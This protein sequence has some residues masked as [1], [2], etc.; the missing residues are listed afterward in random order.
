MA[1]G[2]KRASTRQSSAAPTEPKLKSGGGSSTV[3]P[4][5]TPAPAPARLPQLLPGLPGLPELPELPG[6]PE[7][8]ALVKQDNVVAVQAALETD[9][10]VR[11]SEDMVTHMVL[12]IRSHDMLEVFMDHFREGREGAAGA[13]EAAQAH[14]AE[15]ALW[16]RRSDL[17]AQAITLRPLRDTDTRVITPPRDM[18]ATATDY[19]LEHGADLKVDDAW[20]AYA[21]V[22]W[23]IKYDQPALLDRFSSRRSFR[24]HRLNDQGHKRMY[25]L[26]KHKFVVSAECLMALSRCGLHVSK[27]Q[28]LIAGK[29]AL[30][31]LAEHTAQSVT[32]AETAEAFFGNVLQYDHEYLTD[33]SLAVSV[34]AALRHFCKT[35]PSN[36][37][38]DRVM[39]AING[40]YDMERIIGAMNLW[41]ESKKRP[42]FGMGGFPGR[43]CAYLDI[44]RARLFPA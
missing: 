39:L 7:L 26:L 34:A 10:A 13:G 30:P 3:P 24:F 17:F 35:K 14:M 42:L 11:K 20:I 6:L 12:E 43:D 4:A 38:I 33:D 18:T 37:D 2:R 31:L 8:V 44:A 41:L 25:G 16:F 5:N 40:V 19:L 28:I 15:V 23:A 36:K 32:R 9:E 29:A 22:G 1:H 27:R 21:V